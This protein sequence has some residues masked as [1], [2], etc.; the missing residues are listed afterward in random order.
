[1]G[2]GCTM[3]PRSRVAGVTP[4]VVALLTACGAVSEWCGASGPKA[5]P[6]ARAE[7]GIEGACPARAPA[8][9]QLPNVPPEL[10]R[11]DYWLERSDVDLDEPV[12]AVDDLASHGDSLRLGPTGAPR[13]TDLKREV[14][15][16]EVE[17]ELRARLAFLRERLESG[18]YE[19]SASGARESVSEAALSA[20]RPER[21]LRVAL[22][23]VR[24][25]CAPFEAPIHATKPPSRF[26]RNRCSSVRAQQAIEVL[27]RLANGF[28]LARSRHALG[29]VAAGAPLSVSVPEPL[30]AVVR[31]GPRMQLSRALDLE[32]RAIEGVT[33]LP[34]PTDESVV[35]ASAAAFESR[36]LAAGQARATQR[37]LTRRAFLSEAFRY[38]GSPYGWGDEGG[39]RDCSRLVLDVLETFGLNVPRTSG[40]QS[41]A[42]TYTVAVPAEASET[43]RLSLLDE[44]LRRGIVLVH[45]Q[46]HIMIYL[47][48]DRQGVP[49]VLHALAE[50]LAPC[51]RGGE[52]LF[53]VSG[54]HVTGLDLGAGTSRRSFL[55]RIANLTVF[56][57]PPGYALQ[58]LA[59]FRSAAAPQSLEPGAC[60][61]SADVALFRS[62]REPHS[63]TAL[64]V[65]AATTDDTRPAR[66]WLVDPEGALQQP[67]VHEL[68]VGPFTRWVEVA[69]PRAG[70][71][72][73]LVADGARMLACEHFRVAPQAARVAPGAREPNPG[74]MTSAWRW[75]RDTEH[76]YAGFVE[77][78]F[79]YPR[80]DNR[81]FTSLHQLLSDPS[82]NLLYDH[83]GL[84][85]D[86][87]LLLAPDCADLPYMLRAY[88]AWKLKLPFGFRHCSRG[89]PSVPP[90]CGDLET[91]DVPTEKADA[92][93]AFRDFVRRTVGSA[94]HSA[95][96]RTA[97]KDDQ[98]D[99]YPVALTRRALSPGTVYADPYGHMIV[100]AKWVPQGIAGQGALLGADAQP[101][102]SMGLRRFWEGNFLFT[103]DTRDVGAG[104]KAFRPVLFEPEAER[105]R[106]LDNAELAASPEFAPYSGE[107]YTM[108]PDGFYKGMDEL[109][110]PRAVAV[111]DSLRRLVDA[112]EEQTTRRIS[113]VDNGEA[114]M[115]GAR[116]VMPMPEG[117]AIF[118]TEG[119][120][121]DFATPSRDM[122]LLIAIAT[123]RAFPERVRETPERYGV[124]RDDLSGTISGLSESLRVLLGARR[125]AYTR[126]DGTAHTLS[127]TDVV[128]RAEA[129]EMAYNPNDCVELRWGAPVGSAEAAPC[130]RA[131]PPAQ[132]GRMATYR[133]WFH[134]RARP[135][136]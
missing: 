79:S 55:Q 34:A 15:A 95:S 86:A 45:L 67:E 118:E 11:L 12:L 75:A 7:R 23:A 109:I 49:R 105:M 91:P 22:A 35:V 17:E 1:M 57:K 126:S 97:P 106:A 71:W 2:G 114:Y 124:S 89:R 80:D 47:G 87:R 104:F 73:A 25:H 90:R 60:S 84:G 108:T 32:G 18:E 96:G 56:G 110:Y 64:R 111:D 115:R 85:E 120:W 21:S 132:R 135:P 103:P 123:V 10:S 93:S 130:K 27:G 4:F 70:R 65:I 48:R 59:T 46:G 107:Q 36:P 58:A 129:L 125:F 128:D 94:V 131:A 117:H 14:E 88:F 82:R 41:H 76:L 77:H 121:E 31:A 72:T 6:G 112:L 29:F 61:D 28:M 13:L 92:V 5:S 63:G 9:Q 119:P 69:T 134:D 68:G 99:L 101:D 133:S 26:D 100:V 44:A 42:G 122:R 116:S 66:L 30:A 43:E 16:A 83:L 19:T 33:L 3:T 40:E 53:E 62:P 20:F 98:T 136:R 113:A 24:L 74:V 52:T 39:G 51:A 102:A 50:Y 78:L 38:I 37:P 81:T 127:L 54:I 8:P